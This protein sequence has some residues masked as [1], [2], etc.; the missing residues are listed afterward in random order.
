MI[1][2]GHL[3]EFM[4]VSVLVIVP[5]AGTKCWTKQFK[6]GKTYFGSQFKETQSRGKE[7]MVSGGHTVSTDR[8]PREAMLVLRYVLFFLFLWGPGHRNLLSTL[9]VGFPP[10]LNL[11]G[12]HLTDIPRS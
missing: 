4:M 7:M 12:N 9:S 8:K 11:Y 1:L 5:N 10:Q 6:K 2:V 3:E